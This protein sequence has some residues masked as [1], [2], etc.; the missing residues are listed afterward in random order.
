MPI[1]RSWL[2]RRSGRVQPPQHAGQRYDVLVCQSGRS[3]APTGSN[4]DLNE[5]PTSKG[6]CLYGPEAQSFDSKM[7]RAHAEAL[8][9]LQE[10]QKSGQQYVMFRH[11]ASTSGPGRQ[12]ARSVVRGLMR[13]PQATAYIVR[14]DC[15]Q[16][17]TVFVARIRPLPVEIMRLPHHSNRTCRTLW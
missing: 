11:G 10:A 2:G 5:G 1:S 17:E 3:S 7:A 8:A 14:K 4:S 9:A 13:S 6:N 15:V 16:H 12:T